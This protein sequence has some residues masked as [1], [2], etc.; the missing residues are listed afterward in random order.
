M[1]EAQSRKG[2]AGEGVRNSNSK[3][4]TNKNVVVGTD[5]TRKNAHAAGA[6]AVTAEGGSAVLEGLLF[7]AIADGDRH[8]L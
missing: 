2:E 7:P 3:L 6:W 4:K 1:P 5:A 8:E